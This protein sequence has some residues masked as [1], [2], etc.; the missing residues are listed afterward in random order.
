MLHTL[1][2]TMALTRKEMAEALGKKWIELKDLSKREANDKCV[3]WL[4]HFASN[5]HLSY[6]SKN[7]IRVMLEPGPRGRMRLSNIVRFT[8]FFVGNFGSFLCAGEWILARLVR[9]KCT[10]KNARAKKAIIQM[11][12]IHKM[13]ETNGK[14]L[15]YYDIIE[16][17]YL[18]LK[19]N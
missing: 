11:M 3:E 10:K 6:W 15:R 14:R 13:I 1:I 9:S 8:L 17:E 12:N 4:E 16:G 7:M 2:T 5:H 19:D 18:F